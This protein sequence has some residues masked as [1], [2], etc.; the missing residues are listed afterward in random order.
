[1][2][3]KTAST[4]STWPKLLS[5]ANSQ[6]TAKVRLVVSQPRRSVMTWFAVRR[7][8]ALS[9]RKPSYAFILGGSP[10]LSAKQSFRKHHFNGYE[11]RL[12]AV[13][14]T[15]RCNTLVHSFFKHKRSSF[16]RSLDLVA[17]PACSEKPATSPKVF[18]NEFSNSQ[19]I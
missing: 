4:L 11:S 9:G 19:L 2:I 14:S 3:L 5:S 7:A 15:G 13:G 12:S 18:A 10:L 8:K 1:M 16:V 6:E 17:T